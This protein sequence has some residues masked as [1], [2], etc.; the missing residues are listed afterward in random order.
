MY[1]STLDPRTPT[2]VANGEHYCICA[3]LV[4]LARICALL[5]CQER[6]PVLSKRKDCRAPTSYSVLWNRRAQRVSPS[7]GSDT[8]AHSPGSSAMQRKSTNA[9]NH[10]SGA[11]FVSR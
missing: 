1:F 5:L 7:M 10:H 4:Q 8:G 9:R 3:A 11:H 2:C 6:R